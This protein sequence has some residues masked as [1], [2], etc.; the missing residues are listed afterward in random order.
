MNM[1]DMPIG[2]GKGAI[3]TAMGDDEDKPLPKGTYDLDKLIG[4]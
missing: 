1:D 2:G 4:C 3:P